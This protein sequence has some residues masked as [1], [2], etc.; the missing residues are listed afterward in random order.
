MPLGGSDETLQ[1]YLDART[2]K[3]GLWSNTPHISSAC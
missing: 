2:P 3:T 1:K